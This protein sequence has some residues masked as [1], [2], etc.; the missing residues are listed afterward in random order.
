MK[1]RTQKRDLLLKTAL[2]IVKKSTLIALLKILMQV[3][4]YSNFSEK[5]FL[6]IDGY[7]FD[8][9]VFFRVSSVD[10]L[11]IYRYKG[12]VTSRFSSESL[13][14]AKYFRETSVLEIPSLSKY[15]KVGYSIKN[16]MEVHLT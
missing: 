16:A 6:L 7:R 3:S 12:D 1:G 13:R 8:F 2:L 9:G 11:R 15:I 10:P 14:L 5:I 4:W